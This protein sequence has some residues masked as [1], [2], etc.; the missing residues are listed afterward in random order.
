MIG[1]LCKAATDESGVYV[2]P[3]HFQKHARTRF[4]W[5]RMGKGGDSATVLAILY[6]DAVGTLTC[7]HA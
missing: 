6:F 5:F 1:I 4:R 2:K 7:L 3:R